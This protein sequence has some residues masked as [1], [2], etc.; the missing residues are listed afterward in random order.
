[1]GVSW[2]TTE[3]TED[4]LR[5]V[6]EC[7]K[8]TA[9][10]KPQRLPAWARAQIPDPQAQRTVQLSSGVRVTLSTAATRLQLV[11]QAERNT[12]DEPWKPEPVYD[13][14][15][16][17][18]LLIQRVSEVQP[19]GTAVLHLEGLPQRNKVV[20]LWLPYDELTVLLTVRSDATVVPVAEES[21]PLWLHHG[22]SISHGSDAVGASHTWVGTAARAAGV[23]LLNLGFAGN[24][25]LDQF[26]AR[27][28]R[29][30]C[31]DV[32]SCK[33]GI[34]VV[35]GDTHRL[36]SFVPAL[37]GFIDTI[38]EGHPD[39][40]LLI[41]SPLWC[42]IHESTPG[43]VAWDVVEENGVRRQ[44]FWSTGDPQEIQYGRLNLEVVREQ[45]AAVLS[46]RMQTDPL[47][48]YMNGLQLYSESD[49]RQFPM[50]DDL[51]PGPAAHQLIGERFAQLVFG[52]DGV[53]SAASG[54]EQEL[55]HQR[56]RD[57]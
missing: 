18:E 21:R 56:Q 27:T 9:G 10:L 53:F 19:D 25:M 42:G 28:I 40:Q 52:S 13:V 44:K 24:A 48:H 38:R 3:I 30:T 5:G 33:L 47:L 17:G 15:I 26:T 45:M 20:E 16:D 32:I 35:N 7:E 34:N 36:R 1:M 6:V 8:T 23:E 11:T 41:I 51:H 55:S 57:Q 37:H 54:S 39:T 43:P 12:A 14:Y 22:S 50:P 46:Q 49:A 29:D 31:A 2:I 4:F